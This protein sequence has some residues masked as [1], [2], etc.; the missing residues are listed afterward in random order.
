MACSMRAESSLSMEKLG[1]FDA[2]L[3]ASALYTQDASNMSFFGVGGVVLSPASGGPTRDAEEA[4]A[5]FEELLGSA[6]RSIWA[7]TF[8]FFD[9]PKAE[10]GPTDETSVSHH[11]RTDLGFYAQTG[12]A[13]RTRDEAAV[14]FV[15]KLAL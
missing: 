1:L 2:R 10:I 6:E 12:R 3:R 13:N 7:S 14:P 11:M 4:L 5:R 9:G 8:A 15:G